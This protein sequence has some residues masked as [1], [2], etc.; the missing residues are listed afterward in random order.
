MVGATRAHAIP[1]NWWTCR[2]GLGKKDSVR[3]VA[4]RQ[5]G[6]VY[7]TDLELQLRR[8]GIDTIILCGISTN[9]G[10]ES[11]ARNAWEVGFNLIIAEC[12]CS[13][14]TL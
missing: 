4:K 14:A 6:A 3:E 13:A 9:T 7:G 8:R 12:A 2:A 5:L 1:A 11:T 10:V